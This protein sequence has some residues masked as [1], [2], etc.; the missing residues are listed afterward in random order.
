MFFCGTQ[1]VLWQGWA[2]SVVEGLCPV[3]FS[4]HKNSPA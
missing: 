3:E 1:N 4:P 2:T